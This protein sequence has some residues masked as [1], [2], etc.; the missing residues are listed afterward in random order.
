MHYQYRI[1]SLS[2]FIVFLDLAGLGILIPIQPFIALSFGANP[3]M[4]TLLS[5]SF[6]FIQFLCVP[7]LGNM[8][9]KIGRK[10]IMLLSI[11]LSILGY[12]LFG[13]AKNIELLF[14]SRIISGCGSANLS[15]T[16]AIIA[17]STS[18]KERAKGMN[19]IGLAF[20][21]SLIFG[22][23][24]GSF[25]STFN[26][27]T[28]A[29]IAV[30]FSLINFFIV[31]LFL[32]ETRWKIQKNK[33]NNNTFNII[34]GIKKAKTLNNIPQLLLLLL[35]TI[36]SFSMFEKSLG[37]FIQTSWPLNI[38]HVINITTNAKKAIIDNAV[39]LTTYFLIIFSISAAIFQY[40]FIT[41]LID[42]FGEETL[43]LFGTITLSISLFI[44]PII[45]SLIK[46]WPMLLLAIIIALGTSTTF[47]IIAGCLSKSTPTE[48]QGL[49]FGIG[50]SLS[51][52]GRVFGPTFAGMCFE[53]YKGTP[54][55]IGALIMLY[56]S[57]LA[58]NINKKN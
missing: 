45:G 24:I 49:I 15:T 55:I 14:I 37:L 10:P 40:F 34:K 19:L 36:F 52:L 32:P 47:P 12:I 27:N 5:A 30:S 8:S 51:A 56:C 3:T 39:S 11:S 54:F 6:S 7:F 31:L 58:Y 26:L 57:L 46:F 33:K 20:G 1:L 18:K 9:D 29:F 50:Q 22:S 28:P 43:I 42:L 4:V 38:D 35:F 16:Q 23:S 48:D 25:F 17:D 21:L 44:L 53:L 13:F 2:I 41:K